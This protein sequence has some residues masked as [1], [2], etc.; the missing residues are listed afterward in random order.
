MQ[1]KVATRRPRRQ[2]RKAAILKDDDFAFGEDVEEEAMEAMGV[3]EWAHCR[4]D[5]RAGAVALQE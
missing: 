4:S 2:H 1:G 5:G 3:G